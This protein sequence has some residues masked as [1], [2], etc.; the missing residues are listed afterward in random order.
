MASVDQDSGDENPNFVSPVQNSSGGGDALV[1]APT[2]V[3][4]SEVPSQPPTQVG[5]LERPAAEQYTAEEDPEKR[6]LRYRLRI[7]ELETQV[8]AA[9]LE[10]SEAKQ[11]AAEAALRAETAL[12]SSSESVTSSKVA[13]ESERLK[14]QELWDNLVY[15]P[16]P[17]RNPFRGPDQPQMLKNR[18]R[19]Q[20]FAL[21]NDPTYK[22]L[23]ENK[24]SVR[25]EYQILHPILYYY[26][27]LQEFLKGDLRLAL[28]TGDAS[29]R[30]EYLEAAINTSTRIYEWLTQRHALLQV[31]ARLQTEGNS[32][33]FLA[34][35]GQDLLGGGPRTAHELV[36][37]PAAYRLRSEG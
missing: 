3:V 14:L 13:D 21:D 9:Q 27:G 12:Q 20:C 10:A 29:T 6:D 26:H 16:V 19:P 33:E 37:R 28:E 22:L 17:E 1:S 35:P 2:P 15:V 7:S 34:S 24:Q 25:F 36:G 31:R 11:R 30:L 32:A 4:V 23:V 5:A 18:D 8:K